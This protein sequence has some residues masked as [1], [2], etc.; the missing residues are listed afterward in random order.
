MKDSHRYER[1]A[2]GLGMLVTGGS[3]FHGEHRPQRALGFTGAARS[4]P[5]SYL[6]AIVERAAARS[7]RVPH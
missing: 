5:D 1:L 4:I 2:Q 6:E 7:R 3:D